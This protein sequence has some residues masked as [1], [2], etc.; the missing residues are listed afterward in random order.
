MS[1][2]LISDFIIVLLIFVR[3]ISAFS[4]APIFNHQAIP[5]AGK[6]FLAFVISYI[7]FSSVSQTK[8]SIEINLIWLVVNVIKEVISGLII[9]FSINMIFYAVSFAGSIIGFD[10]GLSMS[11]V[12]NPVDGMGSNV[13]EEIIY[14]LAILVFFVIDGHHH[15]IRALVYSFT[16]IPLGSYTLTKNV[17]DTFV[18][19]TASV[20]IIAVKISSPVLVSYFLISVGE[21]ILSRIIPQMQV[22]FVTYPIKLGLGFLMLASLTPLY[23]YLIRA[24]LYD[25]ENQL[26]ELIRLMR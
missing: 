15:L 18:L 13:I 6:V 19:I 7:I 2:I 3:I 16:I 24:Y 14:F 9:G 17:Y 26:F 25:F 1:E 21:G 5:T 12:F 10:V 23:V 22:F 11:Q 8:I 4:A 20:F